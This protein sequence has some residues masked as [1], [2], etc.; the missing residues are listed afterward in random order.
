M[1][2][3]KQ[4]IALCTLT[5]FAIGSLTGF[6][7][8][9]ATAPDNNIPEEVIPTT[10]QVVESVTTKAIKE[11]TSKV[12]QTEIKQPTMP[13]RIYYDC[14]LSHDLQDYIRELCDKYGIPMSLVI[15]MIDVESSFKSK[16]VSATNDYGLMQINRC[17]HRWLEKQYGITNILDPYQNVRSGIILLAQNYNGNLHKSLMAYNLGAGGAKKLWNKGIY[18]TSYSRKVLSTME[19]YE[20]EIK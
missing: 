2:Y 11:P 5:V 19:V 6:A 8:G 17:N 20:N 16:V 3:S 1:E 4:K 18:E 7:L 9:R 10:I 14:P 15:A 13:L 12:L